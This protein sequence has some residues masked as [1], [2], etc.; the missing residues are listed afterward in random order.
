[1]GTNFDII[2]SFCAAARSGLTTGL[3]AGAA[4]LAFR[5]APVDTN[6]AARVRAIEVAALVTTG[7]TAAQEVDYEI[8]RGI[9]WTVAPT[10]GTAIAARIPYRS[11]LPASALIA[12]DLRIA[13]ATAV[14]PGTVAADTVTLDG[15]SVWSAA[16]AAGAALGWKDHN[17]EKTDAGGLILTNQQGFLVRLVTAQGAAGVVKYFAKVIWDEGVVTH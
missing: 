1:M 11:A 3:S 4:L 2:N 12:G 13:S 6:L 5:W 15:D 7:F 8:V 10:T 16:G 9:T 17:L 14:T